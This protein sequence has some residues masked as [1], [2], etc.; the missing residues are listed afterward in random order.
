[1]L[2]CSL[3]DRSALDEFELDGLIC[4]EL[5]FDLVAPAFEMVGP[6][7]DGVLANSNRIEAEAGHPAIIVEKGKGCLAPL[8]AL[9]SVFYGRTKLVMAVP[10][11]IS[12]D[13]ERLADD[14]LH[15]IAA[16]IQLRINLFDVDPWFGPPQR[17]MHDRALG[18]A[19]IC[20]QNPDAER[21]DRES[22]TENRR[23]AG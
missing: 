8:P 6:G 23:L 20:A 9:K 19:G 10:E 14:P 21:L 4:S 16:A 12:P 7:L 18:G 15:G 11:N 22:G 3:D 17:M 5:L 2:Q 1:M 13:L